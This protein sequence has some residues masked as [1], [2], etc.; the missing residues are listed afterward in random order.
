MLGPEL[1]TYTR[2]NEQL[3]LTRPEFAHA[4]IMLTWAQDTESMN[5]LAAPDSEPLRDKA[6]IDTEIERIHGFENNDDNIIWAI[7]YNGRLVG[8]V[9]ID[10]D[11][12]IKVGH[13][14]T[15]I[16]DKSVRNKGIGLAAKSRVLDWAFSDGGFECIEAWCV[17]ENTV[18]E[19]GLRSLGFTYTG[20]DV[21]DEIVA[22]KYPTR[23]HY[24]M[25]AS[26]W[27]KAK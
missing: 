14:S 25:T 17:A 4:V 13:I 2:N 7:S 27:E 1:H 15:I 11:K 6:N 24:E 22:G 23:H 20:E 10:K 26:N 19:A 3:V 8:Q 16:G 18:S 12:E 5:M 21:N 9:W